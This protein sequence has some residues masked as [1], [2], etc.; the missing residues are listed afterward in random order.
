[1][2]NAVTMPVAVRN[3]KPVSFQVGFSLN[4]ETTTMNAQQ[5]ISY[6]ALSVQI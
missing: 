5:V 2:I 6:N 3:S 4:N 1:M